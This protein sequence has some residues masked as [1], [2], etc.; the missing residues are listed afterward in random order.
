MKFTQPQLQIIF[1]ALDNYIETL[2]LE[3]FDS[4]DEFDEEKELIS[5]TQDLIQEELD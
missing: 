3:D 4:F 5:Q 1:K 2:E